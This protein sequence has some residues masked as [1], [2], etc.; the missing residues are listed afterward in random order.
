MGF[1]SG[2]KGLMYKFALLLSNKPLYLKYFS[3]ACFCPKTRLEPPHTLTVTAA[4]SAS[5]KI[6]A[7]RFYTVTLCT[8]AEIP[9]TCASV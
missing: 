9:F 8:S 4:C 1:N 6:L 2:F 5:E 7:S 3:S